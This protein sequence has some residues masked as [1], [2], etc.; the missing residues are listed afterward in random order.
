MLIICLNVVAL[1]SL[2]IAPNSRHIQQALSLVE[3]GHSTMEC[4]GRHPRLHFYRNSSLVSILL[5]NY[6]AI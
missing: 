1:G 4:V 6:Q 2:G 3:T 5:D